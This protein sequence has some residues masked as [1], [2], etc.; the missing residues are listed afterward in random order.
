MCDSPVMLVLSLD[1]VKCRAVVLAVDGAAPDDE[2]I[3]EGSHIH[4]R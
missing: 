4:R 2:V 3:S 1:R